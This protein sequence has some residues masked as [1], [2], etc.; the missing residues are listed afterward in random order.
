MGASLPD[1]RASPTGGSRSSSGAPGFLCPWDFW[2]P[3]EGQDP[4][5]LT[6]L[7]AV[8]PLLLGRSAVVHR[9][10]PTSGYRE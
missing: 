2:I 4:G 8:A 5:L 1:C 7:I 10:L 9:P 6:P 3:R